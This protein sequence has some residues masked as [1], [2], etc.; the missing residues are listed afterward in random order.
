M[1]ISAPLTWQMSD[2]SRLQSAELIAHRRREMS[3]A[4]LIQRRVGEKNGRIIAK[5]ASPSMIARASIIVLFHLKSVLRRKQM[6]HAPI[7]SALMIAPSMMDQ[8]AAP[9]KTSITPAA[10]PF[11]RP[12]LQLKSMSQTSVLSFGMSV[13]SGLIRKDF[14]SNNQ[15]RVCP[16]PAQ[17]PSARS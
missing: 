13:A 8:V 1:R 9:S 14:A 17:I 2:A 15:A 6:D 7:M 3:A 10:R 12:A 5:R 16:A 4:Y 11:Q